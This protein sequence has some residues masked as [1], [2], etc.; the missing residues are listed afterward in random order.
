MITQKIIA[1]T[2]SLKLDK[3]ISR[4]G[5]DSMRQVLF[6]IVRPDPESEDLIPITIPE[7][8]VGSFRILKPSGNFVIVPMSKSVLATG[9][10]AFDVVLPASANTAKGSGYYDIRITS[11]TDKYYFTA[12]GDFLIDDNIITDEVLEDVSEVN[13]LIF[14]DDFLTVE[15]HVAYID[16]ETVST[17]STWSSDKISEEIEAHAGGDVSKTVSGNPVTFTDGASAPLVKCVTAIQG[18][19]DLHGYDK[20]WVGGTEKNKCNPSTIEV[21]YY[22]LNGYNNNANFKT[23]DLISVSVGQTYSASLFDK[24]NITQRY[25]TVY[26]TFSSSDTTHAI[27]QVVSQPSIL[28]ESGESYVRIRNISDQTSIILSGNFA[29]QFE[30]GSSPTA[31]EPYS[32]ICPIT[33]YTEGSVVVSKN[34][35]T[36]TAQ[37]K[38]ENGLTF[39]VDKNKIIINGTATAQTT[40]NVGTSTTVANKEYWFTGFPEGASSTTYFC[41]Q[42]RTSTNRYADGQYTFT[43]N[44]EPR[45]YVRSGVTCNNVVFDLR[46]SEVE[47]TTHTTTYPSAIYRGSEDVVNGEVTTEWVVIA[48]YAGE[49]LSGEWISDRDE[50]TPGTT[51]TT[52]AQVAYELA[53]PTTSSVTP[54][55]LPIKSL[56]GYN[57]IESST[58]DMEIEYITEEFQPLID[59]IKQL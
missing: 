7:D 52:G 24:S 8:A 25:N 13:G 17:D 30:I 53:T 45:I 40:L 41:T 18:N 4:Y 35:L 14:P 19:Q 16:D 5:E 49:T 22:D 2:D 10:T 15:D 48:S 33:A 51:P 27:R 58:G 9:E 28:I 21:G 39:T 6:I 46:I 54:T 43:E 31:F 36:M 42:H 34:I 11:D 1:R 26:A 44:S 23:S 29:F 12:Q 59:S 47:P 3:I 55:N 38:T 37:S 50:Y 57:H 32:N 20:P 56:F